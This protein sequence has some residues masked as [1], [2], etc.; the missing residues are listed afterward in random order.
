MAISRIDVFTTDT[1]TTIKGHNRT[2]QEPSKAITEP[3][4]AGGDRN[5]PISAIPLRPLAAVWSN[6]L[7]GGSTTGSEGISSIWKPQLVSSRKV[8]CF[9]LG[10]MRNG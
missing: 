8:P 1:I 9:I 2:V 6:P 5:Q 4:Y 7:D 10:D 3:L